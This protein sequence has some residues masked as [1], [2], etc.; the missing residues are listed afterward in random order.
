MAVYMHC[1]AHR[2]NHRVVKSCNFREVSNM[3]QIADS[4]SRFFGNSPKW[5][6]AIECWIESIF[7]DKKRKKLKAMCRTRWV[8]RHEAFEMFVD[9]FLPIVSCLERI[10]KFLFC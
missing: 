6:L 5:Q 3:M 10:A 4:V 8:E 1:A 7:A 2:L 9:L